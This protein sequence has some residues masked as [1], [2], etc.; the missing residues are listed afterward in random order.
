MALVLGSLVCSLSGCEKALGLKDPDT[1][2]VSVFD[3][4]WRQLDQH[5]SLF[6]V[7]GVDWE[8]THVQFRPQVGAGMGDDSLYRVLRNMLGVLHD[9]H[10]TLITQQDTF[11]YL[12]F[13]S[14]YP[15]NFNYNNVLVKCENQ[16]P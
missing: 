5:Y 16:D 6:A 15:I 12:G 7:K 13:Y 14:G 9:G 2:P 8:K 10:V 11:T 4:V 3:E 1:D